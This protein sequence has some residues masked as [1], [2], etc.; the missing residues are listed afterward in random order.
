MDSEKLIKVFE[1]F[2]RKDYE[3]FSRIAWDVIEE[4]NRKKHHLLAKRLKQIL[5]E[6]GVSSDITT[7]RQLPPVPRDN[8]KGF[9]LLDVKKVFLDWGDVILPQE[10]QETLE[11]IVS[12]LQKEDILATYGL[13]PKRKVLFYGPPGTGKTLTAK[14]LSSI[15]GYPLVLVRFDSVISSYLGQTASNLRKI[16]DYIESGKWVVLFDEFD[17]IGKQRDDPSEH[18]EIKRVVNNFMLMVENYEG[19]SVIIA[20]TNH[21]HLLDVG[22]WRRFDEIVRFDLPDRER[23]GKIFEKYLRVLKKDAIDLN[24]IA[25]KSENFSGS[26]IEQAC[27][28][29]VKKTILQGKESVKHEAML[30]ALMKQRERMDAKKV[31]RNE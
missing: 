11:Q 26:D 3:S 1:A 31:F 2:V 13:Q 9:R 22:V 16:F 28:D 10:T 15:I 4:E 23:R 25:D 20:S 21:A 27:L 24:E 12:E 8:E 14:V 30:Q 5:S 17:I 29:A 19:D 6:N 7:S 18:G